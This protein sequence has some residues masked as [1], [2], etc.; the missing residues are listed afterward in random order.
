MELSFISLL[1]LKDDFLN[2]YPRLTVTYFTILNV[3]LFW[4][5][6]LVVEKSVSW[7]VFSLYVICRLVRIL[8]PFDRDYKIYIEYNADIM[9]NQW[10]LL[11]IYTSVYCF[12]Q[13]IDHFSQHRKLPH[14]SKQRL[15]HP[16]LGSEYYDFYN[17]S[18]VLSVLELHINGIMQKK[19]FC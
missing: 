19:L 6:I 2:I 8:S 5:F 15:P 16:T 18:V 4:R 12:Y 13:D 1:F 10:V 17:H 11:N 14:I 7:I 9:Y 3:L